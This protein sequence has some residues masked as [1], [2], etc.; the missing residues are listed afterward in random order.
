MGPLG[1]TA[2]PCCPACRRCHLPP[3]N[4]GFFGE[5]VGS[6]RIKPSNPGFT[7]QKPFVSV[8]VPVECGRTLMQKYLR[9]ATSNGCPDGS[10][11][12]DP[13]GGRVSHGLHAPPPPRVS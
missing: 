2:L 9:E 12:W 5:V 13:A 4:L 6:P 1:G 10:G 7:V 3:P 8:L 11:S